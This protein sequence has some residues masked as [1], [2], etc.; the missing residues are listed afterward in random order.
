MFMGKVLITAGATVGGYFY[1]T[2]TE[3]RHKIS[4][5]IPTTAVRLN[6]KTKINNL[7]VFALVSYT[8]AYLFMTVY[9]MSIDTVL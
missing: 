1:L 2:E 5:P 9:G 7:K 4:S 8:I 6:Y 3:I